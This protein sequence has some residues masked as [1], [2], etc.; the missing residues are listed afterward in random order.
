MTIKDY[1]SHAQQSHNGAH[2]EFPSN[3]HAAVEKTS[4]KHGK[5]G[6]CADNKRDVVYQSMSHSCIL[7]E[8]VERTACDAQD[9]KEQ[10]VS[11]RV[12]LKF[13]GRYEPDADVG[14][15]ETT[16]KDVGGRESSIEQ[17]ASVDECTAPN[18]HSYDAHNVSQSVFVHRVVLTVVVPLPLLYVCRK[19][20]SIACCVNGAKLTEKIGEWSHKMVF[21]KGD[22]GAQLCKKYGGQY[23]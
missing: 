3:A 23:V 16:H 21:K 12:C 1:K 10:L 4:Q 13:A 20:L 7:C 14:Q 2:G 18:E 11:P 6:C 22:K 9:H 5:E 19:G 8:E 17:I 15:R